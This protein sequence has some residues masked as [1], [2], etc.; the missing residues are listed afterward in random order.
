MEAR[1]HEP[2]WSEALWTSIQ[3]ARRRA[4]RGSNGGK[5][6]NVYPFRRLTVCDRCGGNLF[7]EAH[8]SANAREAALYMACTRQRERHDCD[9]RAVRSGHLEDQ[10]GGGWLRW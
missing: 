10:V 7:G 1:P 3:A 6:H 9:Q 4:F 8:R 2:L 5:F